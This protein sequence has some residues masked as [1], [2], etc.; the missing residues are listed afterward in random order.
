ML[1]P[2]YPYFISEAKRDA[3]LNK[4]IGKGHQVRAI[5]IPDGVK[6]KHIAD[7]GPDLVYQGGV[8]TVEDID[9]R[10]GK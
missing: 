3:Y 1:P 5:V 8:Y 2:K 6:Y 7:A 10:V 9:K 4:L